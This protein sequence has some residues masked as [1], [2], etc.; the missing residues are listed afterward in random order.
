MKDSSNPFNKP[1][2]LKKKELMKGM[3][4]NIPFK[5]VKDVC[6]QSFNTSFI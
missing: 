5:H 1:F 4:S 6:I 3:L 2:N